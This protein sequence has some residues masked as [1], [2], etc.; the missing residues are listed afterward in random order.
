MLSFDILA[1]TT[2]TEIW[3]SIF[4]NFSKMTANL[5]I[6]LKTKQTMPILKHVP[7]KKTKNNL[8][9]K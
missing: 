6:F 9:A 1:A 3:T 7:L 4:F 5:E 8:Q 2:S